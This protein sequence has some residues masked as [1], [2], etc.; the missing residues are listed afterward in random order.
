MA[1]RRLVIRTDDLDDTT[2]DKA[3]GITVAPFV[4]ALDGEVRSIDLT[5]VNAS[6]FRAAIAEYV[7]KSQRV[8]K[9]PRDLT[10]ATGR[11]SS[12]S[13]SSTPRS[14]GKNPAVAEAREWLAT[15]A[16]HIEVSTRGRLSQ[17]AKDALP[18][19]LAEQLG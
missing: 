13:S 17:E 4:F 12:S 11:A 15:H 9:L 6:K 1:E 16:P 18:V 3:A 7:D 8:G 2:E 5:E 14:S 10:S 19:K